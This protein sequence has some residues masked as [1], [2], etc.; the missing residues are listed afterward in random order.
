MSSNHEHEAPSLVI[1]DEIRARL[2]NDSA[3]FHKPL[4]MFRQKLR[5]IFIFLPQTLARRIKQVIMSFNTKTSKYIFQNGQCI[6]EYYKKSKFFMAETV[7]GRSVYHR[8]EELIVIVHT[9]ILSSVNIQV[10]DDREAF[11]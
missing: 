7:K 1:R 6:G 10:S 4:S 11:Q 5:M 3:P 2:K 9:R 8:I